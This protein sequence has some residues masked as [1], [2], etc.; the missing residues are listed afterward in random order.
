MSLGCL[1]S[2]LGRILVDFSHGFP[3]RRRLFLE[4]SVDDTKLSHLS[5][6]LGQPLVG[7]LDQ[8]PL[9]RKRR[10]HAALVVDK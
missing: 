9:A 8:S 4:R 5:A 7:I 2:R 6:L 3:G 10:P 1:L